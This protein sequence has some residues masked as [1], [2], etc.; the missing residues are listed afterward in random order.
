MASARFLVIGFIAVGL[1]AC[2]STPKGGALSIG[3]APTLCAGKVSNAPKTDSH[4]RV[5]GFSP[6]ADV[7]GVTLAR[8]PVDAC[9]SSGFGPRNGGAGSFHDG[10]DLYTGSPSPV[11]AAGDGVVQSAGKLSGYG[12]TILIR[13]KNGV[14]TRYAHLSSFASGVRKGAR[15]RRGEII[16]RTGRTGNATAVHLHFE[17]LVDG[18]AVNPLTVGQ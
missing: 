6:L 10:V 5:A 17:V 8:A 9:I 13:H 3:G 4:G 1:T 18:R 12:S 11:A 16:G 15:V 2:A 7:R 14:E